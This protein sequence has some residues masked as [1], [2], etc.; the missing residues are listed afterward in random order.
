[1]ASS[2]RQLEQPA[3]GPSSIALHARVARRTARDPT[4]KLRPSGSSSPSIVARRLGKGRRWE[5][6]PAAVATGF[7]PSVLHTRAAKL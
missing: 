2:H 7:T 5:G 1:M 6:Q 4:A 3:I